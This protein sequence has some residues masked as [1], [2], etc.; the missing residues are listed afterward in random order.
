M[1]GYGVSWR[2]CEVGHLDVVPRAQTLIKLESFAFGRLSS[3]HHPFSCNPHTKARTCL[4][5]L[6]FCSSRPRRGPAFA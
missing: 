2:K 1:E 5:A 3:S 6:Y 4:T